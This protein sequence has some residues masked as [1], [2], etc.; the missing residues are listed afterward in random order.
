VAGV[1]GTVGFA[2]VVSCLVVWALVR[3]APVVPEN[4]DV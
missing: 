2:V 3:N 4:W 1:V